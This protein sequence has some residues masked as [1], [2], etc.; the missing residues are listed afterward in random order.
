MLLAS[1]YRPL[2]GTWTILTIGGMDSSWRTGCVVCGTN[3]WCDFKCHSIM[4]HGE[5]CAVLVAYQSPHSQ[6]KSIPLLR[7][8][9]YSLNCTIRARKIRYHVSLSQ[10]VVVCSRTVRAWMI[11]QAALS[12]I[13]MSHFQGS[14]WG[15]ELCATP[16]RRRDPVQTRILETG[17]LLHNTR[18]CDQSL[19]LRQCN[20]IVP[21]L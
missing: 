11:L 8:G 19:M 5:R 16:Q 15:I 4:G 3:L 12:S 20:L 14:L 6:T 2:I 1:A 13:G 7:R 17:K 9:S 10:A 18:N 21:R